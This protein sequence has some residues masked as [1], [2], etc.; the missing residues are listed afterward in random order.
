M[1]QCLPTGIQQVGVKAAPSPYLVPGRWGMYLPIW[2]YVSDWMAC[3]WRLLEGLFPLRSS[4]TITMSVYRHKL[5]L[6]ITSARG[7]MEGSSIEIDT[8]DDPAARATQRRALSATLGCCWSVAV[9]VRHRVGKRRLQPAS[10]R[11]SK[12]TS[13]MW[14][15]KGIFPDRACS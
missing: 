5:N 7:A 14:Q 12:A 6:M 2:E 11:D 13:L 15:V 3:C 10:P 9:S 8:V 1:Q 4:A